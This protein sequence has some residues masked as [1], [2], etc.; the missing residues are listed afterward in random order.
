VT[1]VVIQK[2]ASLVVAS[3]NHANFLSRRMDSLVGQTYADVDILVI[4]DKSPDN[5]VEI[6]QLYSSQPRVRLVLRE[7][8]GGWVTVSNQG[9][10]MS[11]G[12]YVLF[13]NCDDDCAPRMVERLVDALQRHPTA[14]IAFCRSWMV[15]EQDRVLGDDFSIRESKFR[16]RCSND[17]L[18]SGQEASRFL[19]HSCV[20]PNLSAALFR[21]ECFDR[22]G[23]LS[24]AY[25]VCCD[26]DLFFRVAAEYDVAYVSEPLN[27]FRQHQQTI[28]SVTKEKVVYEEYFR[29][30]LGEIRRLDLSL[31]ER[32]RYRTHVMYL[33][34]VHLFSPSSNG[35]LNLPYHLR[36]VIKIDALALMFFIPACFVRAGELLIK[37]FHKLNSVKVKRVSA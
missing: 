32:V 2:Q 12:E 7:E 21:R 17:T 34:T 37:A 22:V 31:V 24:S 23:K 36:C 1:K 13:A 15:D 11:C 35:F 4:D 19:L 28:R 20:I 27:R 25:R 26:W 30:L 8:N 14:G 9:V 18:L 6:L 3:Y 16:E 5:S 33:W 29:L 10:D